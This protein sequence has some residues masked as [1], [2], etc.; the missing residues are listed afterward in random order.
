MI[1]GLVYAVL[2]LVYD[3]LVLTVLSS[4]TIIVEEHPMSPGDRSTPKTLLAIFI[5]MAALDLRTYGLDL[6][7]EY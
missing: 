3:S 1:P 5:A 7:Y 4:I 6:T 2:G